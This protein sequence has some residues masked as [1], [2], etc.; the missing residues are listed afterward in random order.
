MM[1]YEWSLFVEGY[2]NNDNLVIIEKMPEKRKHLIDVHPNHIY[3][4]VQH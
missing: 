1:F 3:K 4:I 2:F